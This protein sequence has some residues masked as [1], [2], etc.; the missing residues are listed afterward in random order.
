MFIDTVVLIKILLLLI[1][2]V[3]VVRNSRPLIAWVVGNPAQCFSK[4]ASIDCLPTQ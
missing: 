4:G 2:C 3:G 1:D